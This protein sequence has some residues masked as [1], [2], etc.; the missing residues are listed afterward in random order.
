MLR[1]AG[2]AEVHLRITSPPVPWPCFYGIDTGDRSELLA[3]NLDGRRDPRVPRR[4]HAWP[5]S[6][7]DR[8]VDG[9][10]RGRA[11]GSATPASPATTRSRCRSTLRKDVLEDNVDADAPNEI[12]Q[13]ALDGTDRLMGET[14]SGAGRR[15]R[16]RRG[17]RRAHQG[18]R[19]LDL[20][21]RGHRRHRRLRRPVRPRH[22]RL[23]RPG[24]RVVHRRRRHQGAGRPGR[25]PL[26]HDRHRPRGHVR[27]RPRLPGRRA[28]VLPRLH[29]GRHARP[30]PDRGARVAAWP[31]A[32]ARPAA[33]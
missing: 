24:A 3:A 28:A 1:E 9:H 31:R 11:P 5:T 26:R 12:V 15:H 7:L 30:R 14:Y 13:P 17:G 16:R 25:R 6:T 8:L 21:A 20:P 23:P 32:A 19:A 22:D 4:R 2:A 18:P 29:R 10:R 27:R 33:P